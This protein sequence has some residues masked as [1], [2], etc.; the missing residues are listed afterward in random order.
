MSVPTAPPPAPGPRPHRVGRV[1][2]GVLALVA[3]LSCVVTGIFASGSAF[4]TYALPNAVG[5]DVLASR[6][7]AGAFSFA[8]AAVALVGAVLAFVRRAR[9]GW[10]AAGALALAVVVNLL[11]Q[12]APTP[13]Y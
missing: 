2:A 3:V 7:V 12:V 10:L 1:L 9:W 5:H 6:L 13:V 4:V 11:V 8:M